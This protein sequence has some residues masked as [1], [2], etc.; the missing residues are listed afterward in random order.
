MHRRNGTK[1]GAPCDAAPIP[2]GGINGAPS[3]AAREITPEAL[4]REKGAIEELIGA[5]KR[6]AQSNR[7]LQRFASVVAHDLHSPLATINTLSMWILK[8]YGGS[9]GEDGREYLTFLQNSVERMRGLVDA[10]L[11]SSIDRHV[12]DL[13]AAVDCGKVMASVLKNLQP[14]IR[15]A[16][17]S[18]RINPLPVVLGNEHR[19]EQVFQ[20]LVSNA[21][22]YRRPDFPLQVRVSA[23]QEEGEWIFCVEDNGM[24][25]EAE[26]RERIFELFQPGVG[27]G[28]SICR[29]AI[30]QHGGRIW[31]VSE[32]SRGS[33]FL[34]AIPSREKQTCLGKEASRTRTA[35]AG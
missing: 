35:S 33:R 13:V 19:L 12:D 3:L 18:I 7:D 10:V 26:Y 2:D 17:A 15:A 34:F 4:A 8:E 30:E 24:G 25:I 11:Q 21:I 9:L 20:N 6:L 31:V 28:L 23:T 32:P 29:R 22:C 5:N 16:E 14:E 1:T 27:M